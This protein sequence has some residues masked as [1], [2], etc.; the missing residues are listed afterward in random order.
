[1]Q[2]YMFHDN[3]VMEALAGLSWFSMLYKE[4]VTYNFGRPPSSAF[5][6]LVFSMSIIW[7][8]KQ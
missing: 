6:D 2:D 4:N 7:V 1:M 8:Q 3:F 5:G